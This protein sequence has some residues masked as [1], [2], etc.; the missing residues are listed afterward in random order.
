MSRRNPGRFQLATIFASLA[1]ASVAQGATRYVGN[2]GVD[3]SDCQVKASPCR[4]IGWA[5][6]RAQA[7]DAIVVGPGRYGD[8]DADGTLGEPG[9]ETPAP[10]CGCMLAVNKGV[11]V[12]SSHGAAATVIDARSVGGL[13]ATVLLLMDGGEFGRPGKGFTVTSSLDTGGAGIG[14]DSQGIAVRGNQVDAGVA[15][16]VATRFGIDTVDFPQE[17]LLEGNQVTGW[18]TGV[19]LRG[20]GKTLRKN[21]IALNG[22]GVEARAGGVVGNVVTGNVDG[23]DLSGSTDVVG[24]AVHG[25]RRFGLIVYPPFGG[26]IAKNNV[27]GNDGSGNCGLLNQGVVGLTATANYWGAASGPGADPADDVC[28]NLGF[29]ATTTTTPFAASATKVKARIKP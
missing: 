24:N 17:V 6:A 18:N 29:G 3:G 2:N 9:E 5:I 27:F 12:T 25:N 15:P 23:L 4:S 20:A 11:S 14:I 13:N 26:I 22:L 21:V 7:G 16:G 28:N 10:G 19:R 8:L 1:V